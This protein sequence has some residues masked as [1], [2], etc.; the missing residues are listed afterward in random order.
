MV[1]NMINTDD[2]TLAFQK[3]YGRPTKLTDPLQEYGEHLLCGII[4]KDDC[5][6]TGVDYNVL[7][8]TNLPCD[9]FEEI[10]YFL[11]ASLSYLATGHDD[12][13][14]MINHWSEFIRLN[15]KQFADLGLK[16]SLKDMDFI[17]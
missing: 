1:F 15:T 17:S 3:I 5:E 13:N 11:P 6:L 16:L 2:N 7:F 4:N 8:N 9:R 10:L 14:E 12:C